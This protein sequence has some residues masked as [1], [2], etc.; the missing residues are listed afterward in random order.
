MLGLACLH[1]TTL[2]RSGPTLHSM[3]LNFL[4]RPLSLDW[5]TA[6]LFKLDFHQTQSNL[7]K[8][9]RMPRHDW[10]SAKPKEPMSHLSLS[11]CTGSRLQLASS[12]R[13]W[14]FHIEQPQT[15][16]APTSTH[17]LQSTSSPEVWDLRVSIT[18]WCHHREA[19]NHFPEHFHSPFLAGGLNPHLFRHH[20][21]SY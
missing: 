3:Q 14:C 12:T 4:S 13:H 2:E 21:T 15:Q 5:T 1:C 18:S 19:Q 8:W 17:L 16:H 11:P 20:L 6:M 7:Y 9:F 10:S